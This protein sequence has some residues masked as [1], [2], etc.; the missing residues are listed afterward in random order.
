MDASRNVLI[1]G[2][3]KGAPSQKVFS[4]HQVVD[5]V[6][7]DPTRFQMRMDSG[8]KLT[9]Q[10]D[11][12]LAATLMVERLHHLIAEVHAEYGNEGKMQPL[13]TQYAAK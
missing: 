11:T 6:K 4:M 9:L 10:M 2:T 12:E 8:M 5:V 3:S 1:V 7:L 13:K